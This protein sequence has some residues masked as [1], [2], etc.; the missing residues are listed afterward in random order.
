[1]LIK[2][3]RKEPTQP[4]VDNDKNWDDREPETFGDEPPVRDPKEQS[5]P[6]RYEV[7]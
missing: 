7:R 6:E 2:D 1:M 3:K 5:D 4:T